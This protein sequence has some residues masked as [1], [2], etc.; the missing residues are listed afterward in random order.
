MTRLGRLMAGAAVVLLVLVGTEG[1][2]SAHAQLE[3]TSPNQSSVFRR[4][5]RDRLRISARHRSRRPA[6]GQ[7]GH[8]PP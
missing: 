3:S 4:A 5:R 8:P 7:R 1:T 6:S 2:A